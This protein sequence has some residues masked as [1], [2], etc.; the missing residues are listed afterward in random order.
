MCSETLFPAVTSMP[1]LNGDQPS[2]ALVPVG[3]VPGPGLAVFC[4]LHTW[5]HSPELRAQAVLP[6]EGRPSSG[7]SA[8]PGAGPALLLSQDKAGAVSG[9]SVLSPKQLEKVQ[10]R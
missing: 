8:A 2:P 3:S 10:S 1:G 7:P 9:P 4:P 6:G 5:G